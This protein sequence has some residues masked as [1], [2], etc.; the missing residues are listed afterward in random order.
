[1]TSIATETTRV[2]IT[3][4]TLLVMVPYTIQHILKLEKAGKFPPRQRF[5]ENRVGWFKDE[6][7]AWQH[8][9]WTPP[10]PRVAVAASPPD[11]GGVT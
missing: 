10:P 9:R 6:V 5:G 8:G 11:M 4:K 7:V 1:M 2:V 3:R